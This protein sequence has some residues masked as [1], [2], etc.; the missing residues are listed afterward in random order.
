MTR[1]KK[2]KIMPLDY[3]RLILELQNNQTESKIEFDL[4]MLNV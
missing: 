3:L 1:I 4:T 2:C